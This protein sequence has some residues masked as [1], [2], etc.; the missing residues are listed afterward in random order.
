LNTPVIRH[1]MRRPP[2]YSDSFLVLGNTD[3][4]TPIL[5]NS[6]PTSIQDAETFPT[7][8]L[9]PSRS[10][11]VLCFLF[12][13]KGSFHILLISAF[14]TLFY[15]LYVNKSENAGILTTINTY[16]NPIV[17]NCQNNWGNTTKWLIH[18][19]LT[20]ELNVS[21]I[22]AAGNQEATTRAA[23]NQTLLIWSSMYSVIC[24]G[25]CG[26]ASL[27]VWCKGWKLPWG[28][29][30]AEN[31]MFVVLLGLYEFFFFRT[32]I[33]NYE[34]IGTAE[35]NQYIVDGLARCSA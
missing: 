29:I 22:D 7:P 14:E 23:Y 19:V 25:I 6:P 3:I 34:T 35:L 16:Y 27:S 33:Y 20:N 1:I 18:E 21:Q 31:F 26:I 13:F 9:R 24:L 5:T 17:S 2:S 28:R 12:A 4:L 32:I 30:L 8:Q 10:R 11:K 15:F